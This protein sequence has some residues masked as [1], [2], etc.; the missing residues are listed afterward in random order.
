VKKQRFLSDN[1]VNVDFLRGVGI[2][3]VV[4]GHFANPLG[5]FIYSWHMPLFFIISG[6]LTNLDTDFILFIKKQLRRLIYPF[7]IWE[8]ISLLALYSK[9]I[10]LNRL[11]PDFL[12]LTFKSLLWMNYN[13]LEGQ[14]GFV[15]WFLPALFIGKLLMY[16]LFHFFS[17]QLIVV[18]IGLLSFF[19]SFRFSGFFNSDIGLNICVWMILGKIIFTSKYFKLFNNIR[20]TLLI[21]IL[22]YFFYFFFGT[23]HLDVANKN[24]S[25]YALIN[26][27]WA[28]IVIILLNQLGNFIFKD[29]RIIKFLSIQTMAIFVLHPYT[30]NIANALLKPIILINFSWILETI[31]S[32][33]LMFIVIKTFEKF[34]LNRILCL[35]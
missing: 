27:I 17:N 29:S 7:L 18:S 2:I 6:Y 5:N 3:A 26:I 9:N 21:I 35:T 1:S 16:L 34:N 25:N 31:I 28:F 13:I 33:L 19:L 11:Q 8:T 23:P 14:Y 24:Y 4:V 10:T 12:L 30:N 20:Y 32:F 15:L 22:L